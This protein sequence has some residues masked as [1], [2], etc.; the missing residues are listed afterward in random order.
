MNRQK[1]TLPLL[2]YIFFNNFFYYKVFFTSLQVVVIRVGS[3]AMNPVAAA[4]I[5]GRSHCPAAMKRAVPA[6]PPPLPS[7]GPFVNDGGRIAATPVVA[8]AAGRVTA[9]AVRNWWQLEQ[10][11]PLAAGMRSSVPIASGMKMTPWCLAIGLLKAVAATSLIGGRGIIR[12]STGRPRGFSAPFPVKYS[13]P[14][15]H[16]APSYK[17]QRISS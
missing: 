13:S 1:L 10:P 15:V 9:F 16:S 11:A 5:S 17:P 6:P 3:C 8:P 4:T 12:F 7:V 2:S 14:S